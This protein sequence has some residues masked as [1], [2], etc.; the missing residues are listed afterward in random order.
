MGRVA[1]PGP[2][3]TG[4]HRLRWGRSG[5]DED[6]DR[7]TASLAG[8]AATL[9][10]LVVCLFLVNALRRESMVEDCLMAGQRNCDLLLARLR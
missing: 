4:V 8:L 10:V 6:A 3:R 9:A 1:R 2:E 7:Q 5:A